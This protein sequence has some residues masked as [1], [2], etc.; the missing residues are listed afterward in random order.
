MGGI[1]IA[2]YSKELPKEFQ[3]NMNYY[4]QAFLNFNKGEL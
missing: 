3:E 2:K 4:S 1:F